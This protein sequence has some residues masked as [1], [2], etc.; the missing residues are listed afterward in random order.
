MANRGISS[1]I[2]VGTGIGG[3]IIIDRKL[4]RGFS[5]VGGEAGQHDPQPLRIP[6]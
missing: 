4:Y 1:V 2:Y 5:N 6:V 3:G